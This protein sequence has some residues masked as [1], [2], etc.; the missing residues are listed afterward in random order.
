M[1]MPLFSGFQNKYRMKQQEI[2]ILKT[3][4]NIFNLEQA[5]EMEVNVASVSYQNA[6][7]SLESQRKNMTLAKM[8]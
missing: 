4:N 5:I 6:L 7:T 1:N 3:K 8:F 2:T